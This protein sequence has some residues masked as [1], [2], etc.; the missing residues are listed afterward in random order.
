M[1]T[2]AVQHSQH[3]EAAMEPKLTPF[4]QTP[5]TG[6]SLRQISADAFYVVNEVVIKRLGPIPIL[7]VCSIRHDPFPSISYCF[8]PH[9]F[10]GDFHLLPFKVQRF[11]AEKAELCR[12]RVR[13]T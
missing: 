9:P 7:K 1:A 10:K 12:P 11:V 6:A 3:D 2:A 4:K 5:G 8:L 13:W